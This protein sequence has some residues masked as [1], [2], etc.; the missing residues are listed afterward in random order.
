[1]KNTLLLSILV[2]SIVSCSFAPFNSAKTARSLGKDKWGVD[3]GLSAAPYISISQGMSENFDLWASGE[4]QFGTV[5]ALGGK[6]AFRN[7]I[8][9]LSIAGEGALFYAFDAANSR[10]YY[11]GPIISYKAGWFEPY[12]SARYNWVKWDFAELTSEEQDDIFFDF[13][14]FEQD[15]DYFQGTVGF[16]F[17]FNENVALNINGKYLKLIGVDGSEAEWMPGISLIF[18]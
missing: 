9:G 16:N 5:L 15:F 4:L 10:G 13:F 12:I 2:F 1:M 14:V 11:L 8:D 6:Y 17:W 7:N 3:A 18:R